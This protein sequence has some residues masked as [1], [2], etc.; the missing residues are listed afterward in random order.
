MGRNRKREKKFYRPDIKRR[1]RAAFATVVTAY[2]D[3]RSIVGQAGSKD[4]SKITGGQGAQYNTDDRFFI[5][6]DFCVDVEKVVR[7][8]LDTHQQHFFHTQIR[9]K[10]L[11]LRVQSEDFMRFQ[12]ILGRTFIGRGLFPLNKYF[13]SLKAE[14]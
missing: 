6:I 9:D 13:R 4:Y 10:D 3:V 5:L 7:D 11:D 1:Q 8:V 2:N 12:E 14:K